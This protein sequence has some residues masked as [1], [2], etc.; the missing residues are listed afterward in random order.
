MV[1]QLFYLSKY[2]ES[3]DIISMQ[4]W[5]TSQRPSSASENFQK[6]G[7]NLYIILR[8]SNFPNMQK[9]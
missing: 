1:W 4:T 5:K 2:A 8:G 3:Y 6:I 7:Q 9:I